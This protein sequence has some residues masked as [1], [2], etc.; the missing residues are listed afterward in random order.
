MKQ[1]LDDAAEYQAKTSDG[2]DVALLDDQSYSGLF[3]AAIAGLM[4]RQVVFGS[5]AQ[6]AS[7]AWLV[8][9][10]SPFEIVK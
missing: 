6:I 4:C 10:L 3:L 8:S 1:H 9:N 7:N 2:L 5:I